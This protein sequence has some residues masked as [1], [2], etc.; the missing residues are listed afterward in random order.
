M[1]PGLLGVPS[2][3]SLLRRLNIIIPICLDR[4]ANQTASVA[5]DQV[6][7]VD[8][9]RTSQRSCLNPRELVNPGCV[10]VGGYLEKAPQDPATG[11]NLRAPGMWGGYERQLCQ[12]LKMREVLI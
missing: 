5:Q 11:H 6:P 4:E 8:S 12:F 7:S 3:L 2:P 1:N 10:N 9:G